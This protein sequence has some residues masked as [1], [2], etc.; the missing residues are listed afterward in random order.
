[1]SKLKA[2]KIL[3]EDHQLDRLRDHAVTRKPAVSIA[4]IIR[5]AI[6]AYLDSGTAKKVK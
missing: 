1:M 3:L 4:H 5:E 2:F 6:E